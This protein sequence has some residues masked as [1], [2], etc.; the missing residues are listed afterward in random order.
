MLLLRM[1]RACMGTSS[2][3]IAPRGVGLAHLRNGLTKSGLHPSEDSGHFF[4][5]LLRPTVTLILGDQQSDYHTLFST[6]AKFFP[7]PSSLQIM[8]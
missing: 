2:P 1:D 6:C 5:S 4:S 7:L 3:D 8:P